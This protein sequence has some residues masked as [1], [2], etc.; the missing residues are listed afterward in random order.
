MRDDYDIARATNR[1]DAERKPVRASARRASTE[2]V[3]NQPRHVRLKVFKRT[4]C[5]GM[6]EDAFS[7]FLD[8]RLVPFDKLRVPRARSE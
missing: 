1:G 4:P 6:A 5:G 3:S 2:A 7:G 8:S